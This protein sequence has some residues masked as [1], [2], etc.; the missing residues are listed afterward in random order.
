MAAAAPTPRLGEQ[1]GSA[2]PARETPRRL[3]LATGALLASV[4]LVVLLVVR[5]WSGQ[6]T[7]V[8][9]TP[10]AS[11][12]PSPAATLPEAPMPV[13][14]PTGSHYAGDECSFADVGVRETAPDGDVVSCEWQDDG[15][16]RWVL[17]G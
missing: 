1:T 5:P 14:P 2:P 9:P 7:V 17:A 6:P 10:S 12:A 3:M 15:T 8:T 11:T 13:A 16:Y 4:G